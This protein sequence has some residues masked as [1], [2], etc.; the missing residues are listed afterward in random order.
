MHLLPYSSK[1]N[2]VSERESATWL[3][4]I[5]TLLTRRRERR[6]LTTQ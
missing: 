1:P 6:V 5:D 4:E 2:I 3:S